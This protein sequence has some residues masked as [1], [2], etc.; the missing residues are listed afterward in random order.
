[1]SWNGHIVVDVDLHRAVDM[2]AIA[3]GDAVI[4]REL[5]VVF[6]ITGGMIDGV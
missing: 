4:H 2:I 5:D 3:V 1:M 6:V